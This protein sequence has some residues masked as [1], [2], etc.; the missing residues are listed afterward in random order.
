VIFSYDGTMSCGDTGD[1]G[2]HDERSRTLTCS[3]AVLSRA[4]RGR[5]PRRGQVTDASISGEEGD[6]TSRQHPVGG[7]GDGLIGRLAMT[8]SGN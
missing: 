5:W 1:T 6:E 4:W 2:D 3:R 7:L 8:R